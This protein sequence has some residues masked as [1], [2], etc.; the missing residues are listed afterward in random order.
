MRSI[1]RPGSRDYNL[2]SVGDTDLPPESV[3]PPGGLRLRKF[4]GGLHVGRSFRTS[5]GT[6]RKRESIVALKRQEG[7]QGFRIFRIEAVY[8]SKFGQ[9]EERAMSGN[10]IL[11]RC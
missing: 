2:K 4:K 5:M 3:I 9:G 7:S 6:A 8:R 10:I 1:I 11:Q